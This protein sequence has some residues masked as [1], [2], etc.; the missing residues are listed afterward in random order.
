MR[1]AWCPSISTEQGKRSPVDRRRL[2]I[3]S[4]F[5]IATTLW[6]GWRNI[7][8]RS[9]SRFSQLRIHGSFRRSCE[10]SQQRRT[11]APSGRGDLWDIPQSCLTFCIVRNSGSNHLRRQWLMHCV[12][13]TA[14]SVGEP[15]IA[16]RRVKLQMRWQVC[17]RSNGARPWIGVRSARRPTAWVII[18]LDVIEPFLAFPSEIIR[19]SL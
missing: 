15:P 7:G 12:L 8:P 14:N 4:F 16:S 17:Q 18:P 19:P 1:P 5:S 10:K 11:Y 3:P 6:N 9:S 13:S 2:R